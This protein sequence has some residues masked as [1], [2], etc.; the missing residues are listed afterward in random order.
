MSE[1]ANTA[2][3]M[4]IGVLTCQV[5]E[6]EW[7]HLLTRDPDVARITVLEEGHSSGL[8]ESLR[9]EG[10]AVR[11]IPGLPPS[12]TP[13][14]TTA[15]GEPRIN[16]IVR[17]LQL[18][19]H[20]RKQALQE[21]VV[22]AAD[23][24][25]R[26]VDAIV[27]GYG[28]C[29]NVLR[30]PAALLSGCGVPVFIPM[31]EDHPVDDCVGLIIGGRENYFAEQCKEPG[32]FFMTAGWTRHWRTMFLGDGRRYTT[33]AIKML[34]AEY[35]RSLLVLSPVLAEEEMRQQTREFT[36][37]LGLRTETVQGTFGI[38]EATWREAKQHLFSVG[39]KIR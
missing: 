36:T 19:L 3:T 34:F 12:R 30:D 14:D 33:A 38:L 29:G 2:D 1:A 23:D 22:Q 4:I 10:R 6:L 11:I 21:G 5:L 15:A 18:G 31:D 27:L 16:V 26:H 8:I 37:L 13:G 28:L 17:V 39:E 20:S 32:T 25:G 24:L 7:A 35:K 9:S